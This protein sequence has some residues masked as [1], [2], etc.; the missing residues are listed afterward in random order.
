ML[1]LEGV[2]HCPRSSMVKVIG[3]YNLIWDFSKLFMQFKFDKREVKL[4]GLAPLVDKIIDEQEIQKAL[5]RE[6]WSNSKTT[7]PL[8][9]SPTS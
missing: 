1:P 8:V 5:K 7:V 2:Q 6:R 4:K 9:N 3:A